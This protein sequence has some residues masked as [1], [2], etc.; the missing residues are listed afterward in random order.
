MKRQ[1]QQPN[2][3]R[4]QKKPTI[5][6]KHDEGLLGGRAVHVRRLADVLVVQMRLRQVID[7]QLVRDD[8]VA[9]ER[10]AGVDHDVV[11]EPLQHRRRNAYGK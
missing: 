1:H 4:M 2:G 7:D 6:V 9:A 11:L 5:D 10:V 8:A 3:A